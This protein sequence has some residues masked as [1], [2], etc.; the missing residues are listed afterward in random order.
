M[1]IKKVVET[2]IYSSDLRSMKNFYAG[3]LGLSIIQEEQDKLIFLKAGKSML[4]IFDPM[5]IRTNNGSLPVHGALTPPSSIHFAMEIEEQ[6]Y[7]ASK[8]L[9]ASNRIIIEKEVTWNSQAKSIYF[10]DPAGNLVELI[11][12]GGWPVES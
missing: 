1:K 6:E 3:I 12:P 9:L 8:Q 7:H 10:R 2:C 4:L 5:R 11:T